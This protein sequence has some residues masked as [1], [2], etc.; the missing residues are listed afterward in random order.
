MFDRL[1]DVEGVLLIGNPVTWAGRFA[2]GI[3]IVPGEVDWGALASVISDFQD[4]GS[5]Y[6]A[7]IFTADDCVEFRYNPPRG[8]VQASYRKVLYSSRSLIQSAMS[9]GE[10]PTLTDMADL[11]NATQADFH[12]L[13]FYAGA[14]GFWDEIHDI[15][16]DYYVRLSEVYDDVAELCLQLDMDITHPNDSAQ[17]VGFEDS[18]GSLEN[19]FEYAAVMQILQDRLHNLL[20]LA[21]VLLDRYQGTDA[22]STSVRNYLEG[23]MEEWAKEADYKLRERLGGVKDFGGAYRDSVTGEQLITGD[24]D[25]PGPSEDGSGEV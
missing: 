22:D 3:R 17:A 16:S 7:D 5:G 13:H 1:R 9:R 21:A 11:I 24:M 19:T 14:E 8:P 12:Y 20:E 15:C 6:K 10:N 25:E 2:A 4:L 23:F 18:G